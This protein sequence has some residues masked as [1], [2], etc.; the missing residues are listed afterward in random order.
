MVRGALER[1]IPLPMDVVSSKAKAELKDGVLELII[2]KAT[3]VSR[4]K[5]EVR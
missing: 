1:S 4:H 2:P 5:V 3:K